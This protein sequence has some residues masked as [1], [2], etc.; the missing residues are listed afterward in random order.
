[1]TEQSQTSA[2][3]AAI[4]EQVS[5]VESM[6]LIVPSFNRDSPEFYFQLMETSLNVQGI[7][8]E[9][10]RFFQIFMGLPDDVKFKH[11]ELLASNS[12]NKIKELKDS[13]AKSFSV[14]PE[15]K[16][17]TLLASDGLGDRKP[18]EY[19][20]YI[21]SLQGPN[22]DCN[23]LLIQHLFLKAMPQNIIPFITLTY[24]PNQLDDMAKAADKIINKTNISVNAVRSSTN[25]FFCDSKPNPT[26][27]VST[28]ESKIDYLTEHISAVSLQN[29]NKIESISQKVNSLDDKVQKQYSEFNSKIQN[30]QNQVSQNLPIKKQTNS[31]SQ[32]YTNQSSSQNDNL[33]YYHSR[34]G[35]NARKC[36][37]ECPRSIES[38]YRRNQGN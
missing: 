21:R 16:I 11:R 33:C 1:M 6:S 7:T 8:D 30:L 13:V 26:S 20:Q 34:Y 27:P 4:T 19:L 15:D 2:T 28:L 14:P 23:S 35:D 25:P 36:T 29:S 32:S 24:E 38:S 5:V 22:T 17:K 3:A 37:Q 12:P 18:S 31:N 10:K 9:Q